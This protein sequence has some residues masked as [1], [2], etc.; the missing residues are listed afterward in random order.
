VLTERFVHASGLRARVIEEGE[1]DAVFF[2]HGLGGWAE[3][4]R[5]TLPE[6]ATHGFRAIAC[7]L[8]GFGRSERADG[9]RYFDPND[10]FYARFANELLDELGVS[11]AHLVG[12]S[13]GGAIAASIAIQTPERVSR[14]VLAAPGGFGEDVPAVLRMASL[15]FL[16]VVAR[17]VPTAVVRDIV[18]AN[19]ADRSRVPPWMY[20]DAVRHARAGAAAEFVRVLAQLVSIRG[21]RLGLRRA[22]ERRASRITSPTLIVWGV[23]DRVLPAR[24][25]SAAQRLVP[26]ARVRLI[27]GAGHLLMV[28]CPHEFA[29]I[30]FAFLGER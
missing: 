15:P 27:E 30:L 12:H 13:L 10:P 19:F 21:P 25:A 29:R 5:L 20:D 28:E 7:D 14:L 1:G 11:R 2:I 9:V 6:A 26:H 24:H 8:P 18:A 23:E 16:S 17:F 3:N 22:W 4:W